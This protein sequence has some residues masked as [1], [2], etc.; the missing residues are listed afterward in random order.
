MSGRCKRTTEHCIGSTGSTGSQRQCTARPSAGRVLRQCTEIN[1]EWEQQAN[2]RYRRRAATDVILRISNGARR[3]CRIKLLRLYVGRHQY[4][5]PKRRQHR[6][7]KE[8]YRTSGQ[9]ARRPLPDGTDIGGDVRRPADDLTV[10][11]RSA[12][13]HVHTGCGFGRCVVT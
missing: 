12:H 13:M 5:Q 11:E 7:L 6:Q 2:A 9:D 1:V 8:R 4:R 3:P 10:E